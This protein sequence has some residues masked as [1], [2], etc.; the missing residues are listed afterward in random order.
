[1]HA[2]AIIV[3]AGL[4][5]AAAAR[6]LSRRGRA[7]VVL[8]AFEPGHARGSS[9]GSAR[10]FRRA[11]PDPFYVRLTGEAAE[12]W[13]QIQDE[14]GEQLIAMTGAIDFGPGD[15]PARLY[16]VMCALGIPAESLRPGQARERWRH[17]AFDNND[18]IVYHREA[19]ALDA[20]RA[21]AALCRLAAEN[22]A[23]IRY[24]TPALSIDPSTGTVITDDNTF[25][26]PA[27]I[28]A[29]GPWLGPLLR[30]HAKLPE[31][32]VTQT[33][34]FHFMAARADAPGSPGAPAQWPAFIYHN[35]NPAAP[36]GVLSGAD[37]P[38]AMKVGTLGIGYET[39][40]DERD[41]RIDPLGRDA[42]VKFVKA[43][44]PGLIP[45]PVGELSCL[46]TSTPTRN[47]ILDRIGR[48]VVA[49]ACSGHGAK[50]TPLIGEIIADLA[51]GKS[52]RFE[53]FTI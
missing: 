48:L 29:V 12:L 42:I 4:A 23:D 40:A 30:G 20:G 38:G 39:T 36:S 15:R 52:A 19:G 34:A 51:D 47:F 22:G 26:A 37:M 33:Q 13:R 16:E 7:I 11:Y 27:V 32:K 41:Y 49:S 43:K 9:H 6:A 25:I 10:I 1:M 31:L 50:F 3:G 2:D 21:T 5:G 46:F 45:H 14:A 53:R 17:I 28:V 18:K 24:R 44:V 35:G 8:E